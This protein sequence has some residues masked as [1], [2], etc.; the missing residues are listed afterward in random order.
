M[1]RQSLQERFLLCQLDSM[2]TS[3]SK[4]QQQ[5]RAAAAAAA[6]EEAE[7]VPPD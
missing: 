7:A 5:Q 4:Q 3:F 6:A 2:F 1:I